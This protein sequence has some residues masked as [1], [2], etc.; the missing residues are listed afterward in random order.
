KN[1]EILLCDEPT[2]A[3]DITTGLQVLKLLRKFN[4]EYKKTVIIIT[5]NGEIAKMADRVFYI[6]DGRLDRIETNEHPLSP[7]EVAW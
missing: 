2:G 4:K 1:P 6:K 7:E 3:L 5:H